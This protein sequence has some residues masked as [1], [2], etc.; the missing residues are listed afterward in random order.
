MGKGRVSQF[1]A[2]VKH[3]RTKQIIY[4]VYFVLRNKFFPK[5][6][7][8]ELTTTPSQFSWRLNDILYPNSFSNG[9]FKFLNITHKFHDDIDWNFNEYGKLWTYNLNYFDFLNQESL[10]TKEGLILIEDYIQKEPTHQDGKEPYPISLRGINWSKFLSK[11]QIRD[12]EIDNILFKHYQILLQNLEYHLMANHLLENG[13]SLLFGAYYFQDEYMYTKAKQILEEQIKEQILD[14]GAHFELSPMYHQI[15]LH[16][17][18]DSISLI[19][20]NPWKRDEL[21]QLLKHAAKKML[22]WLS[23]ITFKN[24]DIPMLNDAA[25]NIAP[26]SQKLF[27]YAQRLNLQFEKTI[28]L[29]GSGYRKIENKNYEAVLDVGNIGPD[30]Q[31]GHA[32]A[33]TFNF[34]MHINQKPIIVDTGTSTYEKNIQR[35]QERST[36]AHNTVQIGAIEQTD[37]WGGFRV[38]RRAK[39]IDLLE[40]DNTIK[41]THNGFKKFGYLHE[42]T[43]SYS[44]NELILLDKLSRPTQK[45]A[46]AYFHFHPEVKE[47]Q[48]E[49]N[50][51]VVN[52]NIKFIFDGNIAI[53]IKNYNYAFGF[54][55]TLQAKKIIVKFDQTLETKICI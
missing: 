40:K 25:H 36:A 19:I 55:N 26:S 34:E 37:V 18:L 45:L 27:A 33:D 13:F 54:N 41:A 23:T 15:L 52:K 22:A 6:R 11:Y 12:N 20:Q 17:L 39:I 21:N 10:P 49:R 30:Y 8:R 50:T 43:F 9:E 44:N 31:P 29:K 3:L 1:I 7:F 53:E 46:R 35:K 32:H 51:V 24:G 16:R 48:I 2:T 4:R 47:I 28:E 5:K 42:R 14:D 38:G